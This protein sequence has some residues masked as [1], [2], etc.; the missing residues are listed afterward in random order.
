VELSRIFQIFSNE[1]PSQELELSIYLGN[2][3][4]GMFG[5]LILF[6]RKPSDLTKLGLHHFEGL[7]ANTFDL[8]CAAI[9]NCPSCKFSK[10]RLDNSVLQPGIVGAAKSLA[11]AIVENRRLRCVA[12]SEKSPQSLTID[13][14]SQDI[15]SHQAAKDFD[16]SFILA[17]KINADRRRV[18]IE[19]TNSTHLYFVLP[20][21]R[22]LPQDIPLRLW[23]FI[24][25]DANKWT[26]KAK[27]G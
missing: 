8:L 14:L 2:D 17:S 4:D 13:Q 25:E 21:N 7:S 10:F 24:L 6:L 22:L 15:L 5:S 19:R 9:G 23:P 11:E 18:F 12:L 27:Q 16:L 26:A 1:I 20:W 3:Y